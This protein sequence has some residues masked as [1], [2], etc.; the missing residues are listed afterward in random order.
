MNELS[1]SFVIF[2]FYM[3]MIIHIHLGTGHRCLGKEDPLDPNKKKAEFSI[4]STAI[5][6]HI[7]HG[8]RTPSSNSNTH[9]VK[10]DTL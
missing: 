2:I 6:K 8:I 3:C 4:N 10:L 9:L 1:C 7:G 5:K